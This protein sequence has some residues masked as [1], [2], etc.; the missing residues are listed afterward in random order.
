[1]K[2][3]ALIFAAVLVALTS[4]VWMKAAGRV[5]R[6]GAITGG[7]A[8]LGWVIGSAGGPVVQGLL[9]FFGAAGGKTFSDAAAMS[10]GELQGEGAAIKEAQRLRD[11]LADLGWKMEG[12]ESA[13][14]RAKRAEQ[15]AWGLAEWRKSVMWVLIIGGGAYVA[16]TTRERWWVFVRGVA[17]RIRDDGEEELRKVARGPA[18][19]HAVLGGRKSRERALG[20]IKKKA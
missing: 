13:L 7:S 15:D 3:R 9:I 12:L 6:D 18:F 10:S 8:L 4:C 19:V 5:A 2:S 1:M 20:L 11:T 14:T 17:K 16:I